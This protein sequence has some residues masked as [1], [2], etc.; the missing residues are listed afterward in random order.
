MQKL[1]RKF[2][3]IE[4]KLLMLYAWVVFLITLKTIL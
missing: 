4:I 1:F 2:R 3:K